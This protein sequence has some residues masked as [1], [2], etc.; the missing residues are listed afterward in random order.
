MSDEAATSDPLQSAPSAAAMTAG[1][2]AA[3]VALEVQQT[4][5]DEGDLTASDGSGINLAEF[6][7]LPPDRGGGEAAGMDLLLDV[8]L[9]VSVE[10]GRTRMSIGEVLAL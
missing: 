10:L 5:S 1:A 3:E 7:P 8:V 9:Q 6:A 4:G 2:S